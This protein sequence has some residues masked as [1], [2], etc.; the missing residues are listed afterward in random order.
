VFNDIYIPNAFTP[1]GDGKNDTWNIPVLQV[2]SNVDILVFN[3]WG[4]V[5]YHAKN[6]SAPWDGSF[7]GHALPVGVYPY[8]IQV[9]DIGIKRTGWVMIVR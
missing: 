9:K 2:Y 5:V 1:N 4:S 3:R 8:I 6:N 7:K